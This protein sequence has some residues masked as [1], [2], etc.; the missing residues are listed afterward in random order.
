MAVKVI[1]NADDL[2]LSYSVN[3]SVREALKNKVITS[4]TILANTSSWKE[5]R[6]IMNQFPDTSYGIH[7][8]LTEGKALTHS[9]I[10]QKYNIVDELGYFTRG[11]KRIKHF[12]ELLKQAIFEEWEIQIMR[13]LE[14]GIKISHI[15]GHHHVHTISDLADVLIRLKSKYRIE[16]NRNRYKKPFLW[17][18]Y[19]KKRR[20]SRAIQT[21]SVPGLVENNQIS[22]ALYY[23]VIRFLKSRIE[24]SQWENK[25]KQK[26]GKMPSYFEAY[27]A[28]CNDLM[29]GMKF[30]D[31]AIIELMCHPG[32]LRYKEE[33]DLVNQ[34]LIEK[35][36]AHIEYVNYKNI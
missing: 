36:I 21:F 24:T 17:N 9:K 1:I 8:N 30:P 19:L 13:G 35:Y 12:D 10:L 27:A 33:M 5:V 11:I 20:S 16:Y 23:K 26:G 29:L 32:S 7:L 15:D 34:K 22:S 25:I 28:I 18:Y 6:N 3:Q 4:S 31:N 14:N 2:G